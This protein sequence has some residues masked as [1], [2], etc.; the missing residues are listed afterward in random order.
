[1]AGEVE[2]GALFGTSNRRSI[3]RCQ[4]GQSPTKSN[5]LGSAREGGDPE[6]RSSQAKIPGSS[7]FGETPDGFES[8]LLRQEHL[9]DEPVEVV[10][11]SL[12]E[13]IEKRALQSIRPVDE[14]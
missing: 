8:K 4:P 7:R 2:G 12:T 13:L 9:F 1:M 14:T 3:R 6:F 5:P 11:P 10:R